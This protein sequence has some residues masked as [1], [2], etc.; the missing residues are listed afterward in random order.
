MFTTG[1]R[2]NPT[3][4][5]VLAETTE[6]FQQIS[7]AHEQLLF[8]LEK[9]FDDVYAATTKY[10]ETGTPTF[11]VESR[12]DRIRDMDTPMFRIKFYAEVIYTYCFRIIDIIRFTNEKVFDVRKICPEPKGINSVRNRLIFHPEKESL[13]NLTSTYCLDPKLGV[14]LKYLSPNEIENVVQDKG[15][16]NNFTEM[17]VYLRQW[18]TEAQARLNEASLPRQ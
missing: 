3:V 10:N 7:Y 16:V 2:N 11:T 5:S 8:Y 13:P 17:L 15:T 18:T 1:I 4:F 12:A 6:R 9:A 14:Q